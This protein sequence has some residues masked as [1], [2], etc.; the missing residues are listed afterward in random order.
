MKII[1]III[2]III[3]WKSNDLLDYSTNKLPIAPTI[4]N[5]QTITII[6]SS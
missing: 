2:I 5:C 3:E 4:I 6:S 1:I